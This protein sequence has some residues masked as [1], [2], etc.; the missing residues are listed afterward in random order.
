MISHDLAKKLKE[1][2]FPQVSTGFNGLGYY[3]DGTRFGTVLQGKID[4]LIVY[5]PNLS[6][7]IEACGEESVVILTIGN[8]MCTV[9]HGKTGIAVNGP[10]PEDVL[11]ELY[12]AINKKRK[13]Q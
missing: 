1:A 10:T 7:L 5:I 12:L 4:S 13:K 2:G 3:K 9:L 6:E 8:G 11:S